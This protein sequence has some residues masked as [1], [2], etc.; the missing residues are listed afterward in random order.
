MIR[1]GIYFGDIHSYFDLNLILSKVDIPPAKPKTSYV[2]IPGGDG[3]ID[4]T[5]AHGEVKYSDRDCKF[6]FTMNPADD[7][8][9]AAFEDKKTEVSNALAGR[10]FKITLDKDDEFYY[11]GRCTVDSFASDKRIR[12]IVVS[13]K[14]HPY[15]FK[16]NVTVLKFG[17]SE[18]PRTVNIMNSRK[19]VIPIIECTDDNTVLV[20]GTETF[21]LKAGT[22]KILDI[23]FIEGANQV[24]ISGSGTVTFNYQ[25]GVL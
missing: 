10:S 22:H 13:A 4:L 25:E 23:Q 9:E 16:N 24:T 7:L 15:K 20:F 8:S 5:E 21:T 6:T 14:V 11:Q 12:Q 19:S 3:S 17:L 1:T 18:E 2:D